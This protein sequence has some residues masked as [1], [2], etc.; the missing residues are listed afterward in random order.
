MNPSTMLYTILY[1]AIRVVS[2][3]H[4]FVC[5]ELHM[6]KEVARYLGRS[7]CCEGCGTIRACLGALQ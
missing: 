7:C 5:F 2:F 4:D 6:R 3:V 1:E